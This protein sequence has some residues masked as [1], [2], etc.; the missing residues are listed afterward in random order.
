MEL[1]LTL[2]IPLNALPFP[3]PLPLAS[4]VQETEQ[5]QRALD[6]LI[7]SPSFHKVA[8]SLFAEWIIEDGGVQ[9]AQAVSNRVTPRDGH[10]L[11]A[12]IDQSEQAFAAMIIER[13][14]RQGST[15]SLIR[16]VTSRLHF[17]TPEITDAQLDRQLA[18]PAVADGRTA[19]GTAEGG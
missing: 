4:L 19:C 12:A 9:L 13:Y 8:R 7:G 5:L 1:T 18:E 16:K 3:V 15:D 11:L 17:G 14:I 10:I 6:L 2:K